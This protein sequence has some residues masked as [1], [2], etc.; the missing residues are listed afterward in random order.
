MSKKIFILEDDVITSKLYGLLLSD[1]EL[2]FAKTINEAIAKVKDK[3]FDLYVID[4]YIQDDEESG[5][6]FAD[7]LFDKKIIIC[8]SLDITFI[9]KQI[10]YKN[11]A[12]IQKPIMVEN[13][14]KK[15]KEM[16]K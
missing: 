15:V 8:S 6:S 11:Y 16:L 3:T 4:I 9:Q 7:M 13:F 12:Y 2:T 1:Y 10:R 5:L 14:V